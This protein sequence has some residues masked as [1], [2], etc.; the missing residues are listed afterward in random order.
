VTI[1][2]K[3]AVFLIG[4]YMPPIKSKGVYGLIKVKKWK[5]IAMKSPEHLEEKRLITWKSCQGNI[6]ISAFEMIQTVTHRVT[7]KT[8]S[9]KEGG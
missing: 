3:Q 1:N 4:A 8:P 9:H 2:P 6:E 5:V 7:K